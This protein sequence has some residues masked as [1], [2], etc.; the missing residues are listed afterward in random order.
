MW[1]WFVLN[2]VSCQHPYSEQYIGRPHVITVDYNN[3]KEI[4]SAI[5]E[6]VKAKVSA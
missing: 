1:F 2:Q 5:K 4:E 6:I 3:S